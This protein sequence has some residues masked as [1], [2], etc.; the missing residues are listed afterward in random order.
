M[1]DVS[2][3]LQRLEAA[4]YR[5]QVSAI[6]ADY[7][8]TYIELMEEAA[9]FFRLPLATQLAEVDRIQAELEAEGMDM[10]DIA[11]IKATLIREYRPL[12]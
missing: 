2:R 7:G 3:R 8:L 5:Q 6:A 1:R 10:D 4:R 12:N 9:H 11:D